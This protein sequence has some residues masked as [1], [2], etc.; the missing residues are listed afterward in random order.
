MIKLIKDFF[1]PSD[2]DYLEDSNTFSLA[3]KILELQKRIEILERENIEMTNALYECENRMEAKID[4]IHPVVYNINEKLNLTDY[5]L[6]D[7]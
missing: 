7:K 1:A 5:T 3:E 2:K 6:G 4:N